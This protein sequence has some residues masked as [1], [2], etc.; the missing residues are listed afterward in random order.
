MHTASFEFFMKPK[1]SAGCHQ[2]LSVRV[3]SG[4]EIVFTPPSLKSFEL[5]WLAG[6]EFCSIFPRPYPLT[7]RN[8]LVNQVEFLGP[9]RAFVT[10]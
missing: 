9:A 1:D 5:E 4:D 2:T 6:L 8:G 3:G 7:R 10:V